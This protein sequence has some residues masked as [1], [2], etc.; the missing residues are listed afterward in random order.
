MEE[1]APLLETV[2]DVPLTELEETTADVETEEVE[3]EDARKGI[4]L[5]VLELVTCS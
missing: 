3:V 1:T 4:S 5:I 2:A